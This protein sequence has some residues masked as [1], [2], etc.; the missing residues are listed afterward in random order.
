MHVCSLGRGMSV[1]PQFLRY[2]ALQCA[3][4]AFHPTPRFRRIRGN[5][6]NTEL[7][8]RPANL[9]EVLLV[10]LAARLLR[11][12]IMRAAIGVERTEQSMPADR[13]GKSLEAR[14]R[15]FLLG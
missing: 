14:H 6:P 4:R 12:K 5:M 1:H 8:Q 11:Q 7:R 3:E 15:A 13:L 10:H 2:A 9:G